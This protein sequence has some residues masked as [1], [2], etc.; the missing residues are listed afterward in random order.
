MH[1]LPSHFVTQIFAPRE[2]RK[3]TRRRE[4]AKKKYTFAVSLPCIVQKAEGKREN[5]EINVLS[6]CF[7]QYIHMYIFLRR[8][9]H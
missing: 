7:V 8:F 5:R 2:T 6:A 1:F 4:L 9:T 3:A